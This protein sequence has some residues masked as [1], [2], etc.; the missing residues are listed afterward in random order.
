[1]REKKVFHVT[2][3]LDFGG[4]E[5]RMRII[6]KNSK[7]T[8]FSHRFCAISGGGSISEDLVNSGSVVSLLGAHSS[9]PSPI[10]ILRLI[11][12]IR[13]ERPYILH[14]HGAEAN[15][16]GL[17]AGRICRVPIC[18]AE[19]IGF[20]N[21]SRKARFIFQQVYRLANRVF[22]ISE[23]VKCRL[24][25][26]NEVSANKID[27]LL[28][29]VS[30]LPERETHTRSDRFRI[31]FV[32][33]LEAVKNPKALVQ[34]AGILRD[35]GLSISIVIVGD[36]SQRKLLEE[37]I[38]QLKLPDVIELCGF[39]RDPFRHLQN[40]DLYV[41]PSISEGFGLALVEAMSVGI[42]VLATSVGGTPEIISDGEN[43]WLLTDTDP[44]AIAS[45]IKKCFEMEPAELLNTGRI[46][47]KSVF[48][49]FSP[50]AYFKACDALYTGLIQ[51]RGK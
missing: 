37:E 16:H 8:M 20:P 39:D 43:G 13:A 10:A 9:I 11:R 5:S 42:P 44:E 33:R 7:L 31:G 49:R 30:M 17:I 29:P 22:A 48:E 45:G 15:F 41:Q 23:A 12:L 38:S 50:A 34:A 35:Q 24:V 3:S 1:M 14:T 40:I 26:L 32:G 19:E 21:H 28:N 18:I 46:G 25:D 6:A 51:E 36:G 4:V 2:T 47:R 27:V